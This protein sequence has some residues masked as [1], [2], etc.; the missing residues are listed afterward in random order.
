MSLSQQHNHLEYLFSFVTWNSPSTS[1]L[2]HAGVWEQQ[3]R[4]SRS[5]FLQVSVALQA[6]RVRGVAAALSLL[7]AQ[8][9]SDLAK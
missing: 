6:H 4:V 1:F 7:I 9:V 3:A 2:A 8:D 5:F